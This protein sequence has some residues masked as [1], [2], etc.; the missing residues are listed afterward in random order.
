[1]CEFCVK[2]GEGKKWYLAMK[3]Y[4]RE[5]LYQ[6]DRIGYMSYFA[7]TF[8]ERIPKSLIQMEKF[9]R[10][11]F[12]NI[13][14]LLYTRSQKR[15]H[16]GQIVPMEDMEEI[17]A[18]MDGIFRL[19][20]PCRRVTTGQNN[21][22]YC[23]AL[24]ADPKLAAEVDD[25]FNLEVITSSEAI[26]SIRNLDKEG[27]FHSIWTFKTPYIGA[28]CNCDQDCIAYRISYSR[29][30]FP[31][32]FRGE[33]VGRVDLDACNGCRNCMR[34]CHF[35]AIRYSAANKKVEIDVRQC[36]GC[37]V[38]RAACHNDAITLHPRSADS[39]ARKIW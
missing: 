38:C 28:V 3:N 24:T 19:S 21:A 5:L 20:C 10:T 37:G 25:S 16:F 6:Q 17:L 7:N 12:R 14:K 13:L 34:Q 31:I 33:Y 36:Y 30:Y 9:F 32:M 22:R 1:M 15:D 8:E 35:G 26:E 23:Y 4:S 27:L 11:P 29:G 18:Q 2:H 39:V